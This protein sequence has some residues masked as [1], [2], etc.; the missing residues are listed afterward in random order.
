MA[1]NGKE[2]YSIKIQMERGNIFLLAEGL[3][4]FNSIKKEVCTWQTK[5]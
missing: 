1:R 5:N 2:W 3:G 4:F